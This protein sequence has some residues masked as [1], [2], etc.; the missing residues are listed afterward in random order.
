MSKAQG[1][2]YKTRTNKDL[3][4]YYD[5]VFLPAFAAMADKKEKVYRV[6]GGKIVCESENVVKCSG[7]KLAS[8]KATGEKKYTIRVYS[9]E[10]SSL[11][12]AVET[13][14]DRDE[15]NKR[16][17]FWFDQLSI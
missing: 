13:Y 16:F 17:K 8:L 2:G 4:D 1:D 6:N 11:S 3:N 12:D 9:D 7:W 5:E 15:A 14:T 10:N